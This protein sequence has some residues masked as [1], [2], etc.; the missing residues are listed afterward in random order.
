MIAAVHTANAALPGPE[1]EVLALLAESGFGYDGIAE[2]LGITRADVG[3]LAAS[4]RLRLAEAPPVPEPCRA[5]LPRLAG[6]IDSEVLPAPDHGAGC[7]SCAAALDAM[8]RADAA[9]RAWQPGRR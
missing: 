2:L 8:R 3:E 5:Q 7:A 4:A 9:Y 6:M 1:R